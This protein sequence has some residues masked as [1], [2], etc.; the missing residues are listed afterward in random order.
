MTDAVHAAVLRYLDEVA[1]S[2]SIRKAAARLNIAASAVNRQILK[3]ERSIGTELFERV[4]DGLRLTAAGEVMVR[5]ARATL[6]E[7]DRTRADIDALQ[8]V[9]TGLVR[10]ASVDSLML[11]LLPDALTNFIAAN[12]RVQ[13]AI[14]ACGPGDI[15]K[16]VS[17]AKADVGITFYQGNVASVE[18]VHQVPAPLCAIVAPGH[19]LATRQSTTFAECAHYPLVAQGDNEPIRSVLE[20]ELAE[21]RVMAH[22]VVTANTST[23]NRNVLLAGVGIA[24][25]TRLGFLDD[26][27]AG[28][29]VAIPLSEPHMRDLSLSIVISR[30]RRPIAATQAFVKELSARLDAAA[31]T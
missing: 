11:R 23:L 9:R 1:R 2:G 6:A 4:P 29:L 20:S 18:I 31:L 19:P 3:L 28:T 27:A 15:V 8:G 14:T 17:D 26:L 22:S 10:I 12:P 13:F 16:R 30:E 7:Y 5:H 21:A 25:Y 24:F